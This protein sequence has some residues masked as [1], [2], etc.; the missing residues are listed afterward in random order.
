[1]NSTSESS[2]PYAVMQKDPSDS[3]VLKNELRDLANKIDCFTKSTYQCLIDSPETAANKTVR[4]S[5]I[6]KLLFVIVAGLTFSLNLGLNYFGSTFGQMILANMAISVLYVL[7]GMCLVSDL[8]KGRTHFQNER[9]QIHERVKT[10]SDFLKS[11]LQERVQLVNS[12]SELKWLLENEQIKLQMSK[13]EVTTHQEKLDS[14]GLSLNE[15]STQL[16]SLQRE[17]SGAELEL[18][19][20][21][22]QKDSLSSELTI[23]STELESY[24]SEMSQLAEEVEALRVQKI[25]AEEKW[26]SD[27]NAIAQLEA[28]LES[29]QGD[30][31]QL[32]E[33]LSKLATE[34]LEKEDSI[35]CLSD[36]L[37]A[38]QDSLTFA[39]SEIEQQNQLKIEKEQL[40][41]TMVERENNLRV[42]C[43]ELEKN[44]QSLLQEIEEAAR[45][46]EQLQEQLGISSDAKIQLEDGIHRLQIENLELV[47]KTVALE[48][49]LAVQLEKSTQFESQINRL[50]E[51][52]E[53]KESRRFQLDVEYETAEVRVAGLLKRLAELECLAV[54][55]TLTDPVLLYQSSNDIDSSE[56]ALSSSD[57]QNHICPACAEHQLEAEKRSSIHDMLEE[58]EVKRA[59]AQNLIEQSQI[60]RQ[61][62]EKQISDAEHR[63]EMLNKKSEGLNEQVQER[64]NELYGLKQDLISLRSEKREL[65]NKLE[66]KEKAHETLADLQG[67]IA[68]Q[69]SEFERLHTEITELDVSLG[70]KSEQVERLENTI[71]EMTSKL[72]EA[73]GEFDI[74]SAELECLKSAKFELEEICESLREAVASNL[75]AKNETQNDLASLQEMVVEETEKIHR[76]ISEKEFQ[77][78]E[79]ERIVESL[80]KQREQHADMELDLGDLRE[81]EKNLQVLEK[82]VEMAQRQLDSLVERALIAE[83]E[84]KIRHD[85]LM[86]SEKRVAEIHSEILQCDNRMEQLLKVEEEVN[87]R[88]RNLKLHEMEAVTN[89]ER[90]LKESQSD[91]QKLEELRREVDQNLMRHAEA[92]DQLKLLSEEVSEAQTVVKQWQDYIKALEAEIKSGSD[93]KASL[94]REI[95]SLQA[96]ADSLQDET[97][98]ANELLDSIQAKY[99]IATSEV[100]LTEQ[101]LKR[102]NA[103]I[104]AA[105]TNLHVY[106]AQQHDAEER[107]N[108]LAVENDELKAEIET[109]LQQRDFELANIA[110]LNN[111]SQQLET[112]VTQLQKEKDDFDSKVHAL[113]EEADLLGESNRESRVLLSELERE[114]SSLENVAK[115]LDGVR[116]LVMQHKSELK[117]VESQLV[118]LRDR[119]GVVEN[120]VLELKQKQQSLL[121]LE[122]DLEVRSADLANLKLEI[123]EQNEQLRKLADEIATHSHLKDDFVEMENRLEQMKLS[124][125]LLEEKKAARESELNAL[126]SLIS[127]REEEKGR[128]QATI[129][130]RVN[131]VQTLNDSLATRERECQELSRRIEQSNKEIRKLAAFRSATEETIGELMREVDRLKEEIRVC[132]QELESAEHA[133]SFMKTG[134]ATL[135]S[136]LEALLQ[137]ELLLQDQT[138]STT[139]QLATYHAE[140]QAIRT[141]VSTSE[142]EANT[143]KETIHSL[144]EE[145]MRVTADLS[146]RKRERESIPQHYDTSTSV[147]KTQDV[148]RDLDDGSEVP[149]LS[150]ESQ[151]PIE[152]DEVTVED[153]WSALNELNQIEESVRF[154][155]RNDSGSMW[156]PNAAESRTAARIPTSSTSRK[157]AW[158]DVFSSNN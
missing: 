35:K 97:Q 36:Q 28:S 62:A 90:I 69:I 150:R 110:E 134:I 141:Q 132:N 142:A 98:S 30:L 86:D 143:L 85:D 23:A 16:E 112:L 122:N 129:Q 131:E 108:G 65:E 82:E 158:A 3:L 21:R 120:E 153:V 138:E 71:L 61:E 101:T 151:I 127:S 92:N 66:E 4:I 133:E 7:V 17:V 8:A 81:R 67:R 87:L 12:I 113:K 157:D 79:H 55:K 109:A 130:E 89:H 11:L 70:L 9:E 38:K 139:N 52:I 103:E 10:V 6:T 76:L 128:V 64:I 33:G 27:R 115:E 37:L 22:G 68:G 95:E 59:E 80:Q 31:L 26:E 15:R 60:A 25:H 118:D 41:H 83:S 93:R 45:K 29:K 88:I 96:C 121:H 91:Q 123:E 44:R 74:Q 148:L 136:Q 1:M 106:V 47:N 114:I 48:T 42:S 56:R 94:E 43:D 104:G 72:R 75:R 105:E 152:Q 34:V 155:T 140:L 50:D 146:E 51:V 137:N 119:K 32:E 24:R 100:E 57:I 49:H 102:L 111:R 145:M 73:R 46:V 40:L 77:R 116:E 18:L 2:D 53:A 154:D 135:E 39:L 13:L 19:E 107:L 144:Q 54:A 20:L 117:Q 147:A 14:I 84:L 5:L 58:L 126:D 149:A 63:A 156:N 124:L 99:Q 78:D 125:Q